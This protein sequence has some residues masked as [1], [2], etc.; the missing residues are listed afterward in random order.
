[1]PTEDLI[2]QLAND[3]RPV[4]RLRPVA[5][6]VAGWAVVALASLA[7]VTIF[8]GIRR[9]LGDAVDRTDFAIE[10]VLL[11]A[12]ALSAAFGALLVSIPGADRLKYAR[13]PIV[14]GSATVV[15][16]LGEVFFA[17]VTGA[18][19]G[20]MT[21]AWYCV[22]KAASVAAIPSVVLFLMIR[23]AAPLRAAHAGFLALLATAAVGAIGANFVC[24]Y[25]RPLHMLLWHAAPVML[26][27]GVGAGL[28]AWLLRWRPRQAP[29]GTSGGDA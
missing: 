3:L 10:A 20:R 25:D 2:Q 12:T 1:V 13:W 5:V 7:L 18:P 26:F 14:A 16:A 24:P 8:S 28:G 6:R 15:W 17:A 21:F 9:E 19:E 29:P 4:R 27:A 23:R 22:Y 11:T